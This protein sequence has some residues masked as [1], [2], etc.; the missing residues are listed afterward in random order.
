M[1]ATSS[2][3]TSRHAAARRAA[4][5]YRIRPSDPDAHLFGIEMRIAEPAREGQCLSLPAWIPGSYMIRDFARHIVRID[6]NDSRR[7]V[8][9]DKLDKHTWQAGRCDGP[10]TVRYLVYAWDL[11]VRGAHLDR[12]H[13][14]FNG[15]SVFLRVHGQDHLPCE[16]IIDSPTARELDGWQ[17]ATTLPADGARRWGFGRY[18]AA[19]YD[20]LIDHPVEM[21]R[22]TSA[23]FTA[24]G[25][26][27]DIAITGRHDADTGRLCKDLG[28][29][30][31]A[32]IALF[33]PAGRRAPLDRFLFQVMAIGDG[34]G[35]L[36]HRASTALVCR[37][38]DLPHAG[39]TTMPDGYRSF[40]GLASHEYFH[41]WHV[42]RIK[43][44]RFA[45]YDLDREQYTRLLWVFEGFTSYYD[46]LMLARSGTVSLT[47][48]LQLLS[49]TISNVLRGPGRFAQSVADSSFDAWTRYYRQDENSPNAIV[50]Y[51]AKGAL[52]ALCIDLAIRAGSGGRHSLDDVMR[53]M[54][55]RYGQAFYSGRRD[56]L[57]EDGL[58]AIIAEATGIRLDREIRQWS[59]AAAELPLA[60][61]LHRVGL[62]LALGAPEHAG[63]TIGAKVA[64]RDGMPTLVHALANGPAQRAGLSAGDAIVAVDGLRIAD[65]RALKSLLQRRQPGSTL[66]VHAFRRDELFE[67]SLQ[68]GAA[69][70][71]EARVSVDRRAGRSAARMRTAWLSG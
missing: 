37:R 57:P 59:E 71:T 6:A 60:P 69:P 32:Q 56:G 15:T 14:F 2:S 47:D 20:E 41:L 1:A 45:E 10:L 22:F 31:E 33:D 62:K 39:M 4:V 55:S 67:C 11:S 51:Y 46:D 5:R 9:L 23:S 7:T 70:L 34:Y 36:E 29:I 58:P 18:R 17:V 21:G 24:G 65:E 43:P 64:L 48:Y 52:V 13:G 66:R 38:S 53:L 12:T 30:C 35:G 16:V 27:H 25:A 54:W 8:R 61:L 40:L 3:S 19:D 50:S 26:L 28:T 68:P 63:A 49:G 44:Q 42:K